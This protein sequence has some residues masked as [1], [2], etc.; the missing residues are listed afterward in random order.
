[1]D[2]RG[3]NWASR[4]ALARRAA[5]FGPSGL[6]FFFFF[7]FELVGQPVKIRRFHI[8]CFSFETLRGLA[9]IPHESSVLV[10]GCALPPLPMVCPSALIM[11]F[12]L[13]PDPWKHELLLSRLNKLSRATQ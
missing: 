12:K 13:P 5:L 2:V 3:T 1:M 7:N 11:S 4:W 9:D 6:T 8:I 10:L